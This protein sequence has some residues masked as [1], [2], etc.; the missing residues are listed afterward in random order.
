MYI[1]LT[2]ALFLALDQKALMQN[3]QACQTSLLQRALLE[4]LERVGIQT[5]AGLIL[6]PVI[7]SGETTD[8]ESLLCDGLPKVTLSFVG[9]VYFVLRDW[10]D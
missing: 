8:G 6:A 4:L 10:D 1:F 5:T 7:L 3:F 2:D 9:D